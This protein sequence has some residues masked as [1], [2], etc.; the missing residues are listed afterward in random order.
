MNKENAIATIK[1]NGYSVDE[2]NNISLVYDETRSAE[3]N[4]TELEAFA[5]SIDDAEVVRSL[6]RI[7]A[8]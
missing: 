2:G 8:T 4:D 6:F 1:R 3:F 5:Y 7:H